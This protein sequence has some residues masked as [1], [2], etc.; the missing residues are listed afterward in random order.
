MSILRVHQSKS[1]T[2][3]IQGYKIKT[4]VV[5]ESAGISVA[6]RSLII[7][8]ASC[9]TFRYRASTLIGSTSPP[10]KEQQR[11]LSWSANY[12]QA[13]ILFRASVSVGYFNLCSSSCPQAWHPFKNRPAPRERDSSV[14]LGLFRCLCHAYTWPNAN[15]NSCAWQAGVQWCLHIIDWNKQCPLQPHRQLWPHIWNPVLGLA[16]ISSAKWLENEVKQQDMNSVS[17]IQLSDLSSSTPIH[18]HTHQ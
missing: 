11:K 15:T 8:N 17:Q 14:A 12:C 9:C 2:R 5:L 10:L 6:N 7:R 1:K 4:H 3:L 16:S 18:V 13:A